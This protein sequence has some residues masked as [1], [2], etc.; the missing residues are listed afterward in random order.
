MANGSI[1]ENSH[2][3]TQPTSAPTPPR[4]LPGPTTNST[5]RLPNQ[6]APALQA[7]TRAVSSVPPLG[8]I[9]TARSTNA[10]RPPDSRLRLAT[11]RLTTGE[12]RLTPRQLPRP[13]GRGPRPK[14]PRL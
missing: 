12:S 1:W 5:G 7:K 9:D 4:A 11:G 14:K 10:G 8:K 3:P 13:S 6:P 2:Q